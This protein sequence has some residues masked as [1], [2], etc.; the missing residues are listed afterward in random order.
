MAGIETFSPCRLNTS[1]ARPDNREREARVC[2][3]QFLDGVHDGRDVLAGF[4]GADLQHEPLGQPEP[5]ADLGDLRSTGRDRPGC[6]REGSDV[7]FPSAVGAQPVRGELGDGDEDVGATH[8]PAQ[9]TPLPGG[10]SAAERPRHVEDRQVVERRHG[11][12]ALG[13]RQIDVERVE[14]IDVA[15]RDQSPGDTLRP[16]AHRAFDGRDP[17]GQFGAGIALHH[18]PQA[19]RPELRSECVQELASVCLDP[20]AAGAQR[21]GPESDPGSDRDE[22]CC[23]RAHP[24]VPRSSQK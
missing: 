19:R 2:R 3:T 1:E 24:T 22:S 8:R 10:A 23:V 12:A 17:P 13:E 16:V 18:R 6:G 20:A 7:G 21:E 5:R 9:Q 11:G 4:D 14:D 15:Q